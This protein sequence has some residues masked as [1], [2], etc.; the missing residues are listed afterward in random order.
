M[1]SFDRQP[2]DW[3]DEQLRRV[4]VPPELL[5]ALRWIA[6]GSDAELD[7]AL[8][9]APLPAG[10][11]GRLKAVAYD[12]AFMDEAAAEVAVPDGLMA[13]LKAI[14][15]ERP[16]TWTASRLDWE[17]RDVE[18]PAGFHRSL[19]AIAIERPDQWSDERLDHEVRE[20][21]T[22]QEL[23]AGLAA[24]P[25]DVETL[26]RPFRRRRRPID[27]F[28]LST[29]LSL[30]F[31][32]T[33][34]YASAIG[35]FLMSAYRDEFT[36]EPVVLIE[37]PWRGELESAGGP[38]VEE[39]AFAVTLPSADLPLEQL[40][41][42]F[43][44]PP[45]TAPSA[46]SEGGAFAESIRL[47][48]GGAIGN[49]SVAKADPLL[50][51]TLL[52]SRPIT[53]IVPDALEPLHKAGARGP[54]GVAPPTVDADALLFA[55]RHGVHA[56]VSP[57]RHSDLRSVAVPLGTSAASYER[58]WERL[59][60]GEL[61]PAETVHVEDFLQAVASD[62]VAA[63]PGELALRTAAGVSPFDD[64]NNLALLQVAVQA[65]ALPPENSQASRR[66]TSLTI[67]VDTSGS[68]QRNQSLANARR[69]LRDLMTKLTPQDR[70]S[71]VV[72][73]E[74]AHVLLRDVSL[75]ES[76]TL[77]A[78]IDQLTADRST[79]VG[80]GLR[81][82]CS[83]ARSSAI[84]T[85]GRRVLVLI[86]DGLGDLLPRTLLEVERNLVAATDDGVELDI[87]DLGPHGSRGNLLDRL[88][89]LGQGRLTTA[90]SGEHV[91]WALTQT[92][93]DRD[94]V[95]AHDASLTIEFN[96][97]TVA[98]YRLVGHEAESIVGVNAAPLKVDLRA[99]Q[100]SSAL[101]ELRLN[102]GGGDFVA[103]ARL[104]W[105][106]LS[107]RTQTRRQQIS[108][109]QFAPAFLEA[110]PSLQK[111]AVAAEAAELL[112]G[113]YY[114]A[115]RGTTV[116]DLFAAVDQIPP[117]FSNDEAF[118]RFL[119]MLRAADRAGLR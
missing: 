109:M 113:S 22:P 35:G 87:I 95:V 8:R 49:A 84:G 44:P 50:D 42:S 110:T 103:E 99:L 9:A 23:A 4:P 26:P 48:G 12:A 13:R 112:R 90:D 67:A 70:V 58:A 36:P 73:D 38:V 28:R 118:L 29:A 24:I 20:V 1:S 111:A 105:R 56:F 18:P 51:V 78:Q 61:P 107:G 102:P 72:F 14:P 53:D 63:P 40:L 39:A 54:R 37:A 69:A 19:K 10:L 85:T 34:S 41:A 25:Y 100:A 60:Q 15:T 74:D 96:P 7:E 108:R 92:L 75:A 16:A 71:L 88:S 116:A 101:F 27:W 3:V 43:A 59:W 45:L 47:F 114:A 86:T 98:A 21:E 117:A 65:G 79:N 57:Q 33:L 64:S 119:R 5:A 94:Q 32:I 46:P 82:A 76:E 104:Q 77:L 66:P 68:M 31:V 81:L 83:V 89:E 91:L 17:L 11:L 106:D 93:T 97:D 6:V 80:E 30:V 62:F 55:V 52:N 115:Q 2:D